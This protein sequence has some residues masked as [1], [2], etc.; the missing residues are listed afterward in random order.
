[1]NGIATE[2]VSSYSSWLS[3]SSAIF[4]F[5]DLGKKEHD[6]GA[7]KVGSIWYHLT[8]NGSKSIDVPAG[9]NKSKGGF[10]AR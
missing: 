3:S 5:D 2:A 8:A 6:E 4:N 9:V 10:F 7:L 1:L